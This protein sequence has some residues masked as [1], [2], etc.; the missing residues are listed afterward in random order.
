MTQRKPAD[1][2]NTRPKDPYPKKNL[3]IRVPGEN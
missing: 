3:K 2:K 1:P